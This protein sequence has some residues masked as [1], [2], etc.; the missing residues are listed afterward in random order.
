MARLLRWGILLMGVAILVGGAIGMVLR[1]T[2]ALPP[3]VTS[4]TPVP[5]DTLPASFTPT[6]SATPT[7]TPT[8]TVTPSPTTTPT[9]TLA[10]LVLQVTAI[11][12]DVTIDAPAV[13]LPLLTASPRPTD[14]VPTPAA[15]IPFVPPGDMP[16]VKGWLRYLADNAA[17]QRAGNW[18]TFTQT[19]RAAGYRYLFT[20]DAGAVLT[21]RFLGTAARLRYPRL[22]SYGVFEVRLDGRVMTTVDAYLPRQISAN[23]D[24]ATTDVFTVA[25][26]WHTL[27]IRQ[28][29][30]RNPNS[31]NTYVAI[32]TID[33]YQ[34]GPAPTVAPT[35]A[36]VTPTLTPSAVPVQKIQ[37]LVAPPT[38]P[39]TPTPAPPQVTS[40]VLTVAY[41]LNGNKAVEPGE[42][43]LD[44]VV[45][46]IAAD[47]NRILATARTDAQGYV[48]LE[49][50]GTA[51][52]RLVV[53][54]FNRFWDI[55]Q[56]T[57]GTRLTLLLPPANRP[58]LIP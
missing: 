13:V 58:A 18:E 33:I 2:S 54:Y 22:F 19:F 14:I 20:N 9:A 38:I 43:V 39:P 56:R 7:L 27:E 26:G 52:L 4:D 17:V 5:T 36:L 44:L 49:T 29:N 8:A 25:N 37:V 51:P 15:Q 23:G 24:F 47:T 28:L 55:P 6:A 42:G 35:T 21:L 50:T 30:R 31:T 57:A 10:T 34:D 12:A 32:D 53:P 46:L 40:V 11:N 1:Q 48:Y 16:P 45:Q 41:D 3:T